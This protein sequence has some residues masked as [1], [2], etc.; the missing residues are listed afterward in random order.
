M[1]SSMTKLMC[2]IE[3]AMSRQIQ[4]LRPTRD[5]LLPRLLA[6]PTFE[7]DAMFHTYA[8]DQLVEQPAIGLFAELCWKGG[9]A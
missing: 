9:R 4:T 7:N 3:I 1:A 5:L 2:G 6:S 8:K